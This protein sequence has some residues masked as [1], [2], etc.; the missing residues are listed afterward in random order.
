MVF[1]NI[2]RF[3]IFKMKTMRQN[4]NIKNA[5][6]TRSFYIHSIVEIVYQINYKIQTTQLDALTR[7]LQKPR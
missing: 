4:A 7:T 1:V 3:I 6:T 2:V 5:L